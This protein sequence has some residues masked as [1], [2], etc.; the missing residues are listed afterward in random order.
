MYGHCA[1]PQPITMLATAP[2][3]SRRAQWCGVAD[4]Q[5]ERRRATRRR[6]EHQRQGL[7]GQLV[8]EVAGVGP[9][10]EDA[11]DRRHPGDDGRSDGA[12]AEVLHHRLITQPA[13]VPD[14]VDGGEVG[15]DDDGEHAAEHRRRVDPAVPRITG[16]AAG[17]NA[18]RGDGAGDRAEAVGDDHRRDGEGGPEVAAVTG[19]EDGLAEGEARS[20]QHDPEGGQRQRDEQRQGDRREGLGEPGPQHDEAEDQPDVVGLPHRSDR[21]VDHLRGRSPRAGPPATRSQKPAPK[22]APPK[23]A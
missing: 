9:Q 8:E 4:Q 12:A 7:G 16:D 17:G 10:D 11:D 23:T 20:A 22:S 6:D 5:D 3:A 15:G 18:A 21:V 19:A 2:M 14:E 13:G 1:T